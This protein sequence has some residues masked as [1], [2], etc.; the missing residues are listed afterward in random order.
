M[1]AMNPLLIGLMLLSMLLAAC[2]PRAQAQ[3]DVRALPVAAMAV[4]RADIHT[5]LS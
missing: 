3:R 2:A 5:S 1:H 4:A